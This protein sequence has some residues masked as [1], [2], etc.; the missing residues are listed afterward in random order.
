VAWWAW[1]DSHSYPKPFIELRPH[2]TPEVEDMQGKT[3]ARRSDVEVLN[4]AKH[5][6]SQF[7]RPSH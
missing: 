7:L 5:G 2:N 4:Q 1:A 6:G 3:A